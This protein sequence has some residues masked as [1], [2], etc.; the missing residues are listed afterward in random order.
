MFAFD[1][2]LDGLGLG[3]LKKSVYFGK[4][5]KSALESES[6]EDFAE[7]L[8]KQGVQQFLKAKKFPEIGQEG[9]NQLYK[10]LRKALADK[11]NGIKINEEYDHPGCGT[12]G[13]S[14]EGRKGNFVQL[15]VHGDCKG[16]EI[17]PGPGHCV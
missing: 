9:F 3:G 14:I 4:A 2:L 12:V 15:S 6:P 13:I 16:K 7:K 5:L 8:T 10:A 17:R 1:L 11:V